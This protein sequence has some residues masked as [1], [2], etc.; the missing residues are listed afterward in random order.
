MVRVAAFKGLK[1]LTGN[2]L[3]IPLLK[4]LLP[5]LRQSIHDPVERVRGTFLD[6][7]LTIKNIRDIKFWD[8]VSIDHLLSRLEVEKTANSKRLV[9]LLVSSYFPTSK[10]D[11]TKVTRFLHMT[12][13]Q[14]LCDAIFIFPQLVCTHI[15]G[16]Y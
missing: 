7:L 14:S 5:Q 16:F 2:H 15:S 10:P 13:V 11:E 3:S 8:I 1:Y 9:Q 4:K 6:L 12:R